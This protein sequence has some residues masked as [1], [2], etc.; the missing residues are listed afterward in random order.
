MSRTQKVN[1]RFGFFYEIEDEDERQRDEA[2]QKRAGVLKRHPRLGE[3]LPENCADIS[4][5]ADSE[6]YPGEVHDNECNCYTEQ[7]RQ[8]KFVRQVL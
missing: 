7:A 4:K 6:E 1:I 2:H 8:R 5:I 3:Y